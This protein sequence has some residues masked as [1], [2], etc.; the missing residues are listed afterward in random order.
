MKNAFQLVLILLAIVAFGFAGYFVIA[1]A[2][3]WCRPAGFI[4]VGAICYWIGAA[5]VSG[6]G[7]D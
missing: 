5:F 4:A 3:M 7:G 6:A 1:G 2:F